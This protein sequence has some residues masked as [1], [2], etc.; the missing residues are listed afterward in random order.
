M[1]TWEKGTLIHPAL[2]LSICQK[3]DSLLHR[4]LLTGVHGYSIQNNVNKC[5]MEICH[6]YAMKYF[7]DVKNN[8]IMGISGKWIG[9]EKIILRDVNETQK[10]NYYMF[11]HI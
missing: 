6:I 2:C 4:Y 8:E 3:F 11:S 1:Y 10:D 7:L 5:I 9:L